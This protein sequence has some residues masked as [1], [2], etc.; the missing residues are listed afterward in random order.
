MSKTAA[1][2]INPL[3]QHSDSIGGMA[4]LIGKIARYPQ[5]LAELS[6]QRVAGRA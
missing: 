1:A 3:A 5:S 2:S 6:G 4:A